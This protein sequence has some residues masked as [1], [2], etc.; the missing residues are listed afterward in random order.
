MK[1]VVVITAVMSI[2]GCGHPTTVSQMPQATVKPAPAEG[3]K[4]L[5]AGECMFS[6]PISSFPDR[7]VNDPPNKRVVLIW[8]APRTNPTMDELS[9]DMSC[10]TRESLGDKMTSA[11]MIALLEHREP[12]REEMESSGALDSE[13]TQGK[14]NFTH[15]P[16]GAATTVGAAYSQDQDIGDEETRTRSLYF[17]IAPRKKPDLMLCGHSFVKQLMYPESDVTQKALQHI[18]EIEFVE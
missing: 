3:H 6:L 18:K 1:Y 2:A 16:L 9:I 14:K 8:E 17:C 5:M 15:Y 7:M 11:V 12:T 4:K 13:M 10:E